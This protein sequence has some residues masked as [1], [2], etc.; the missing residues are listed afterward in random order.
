VITESTCPRCQAEFG[1]LRTD[2][3]T[4]EDGLKSDVLCD[5]CEPCYHECGCDTMGEHRAAEEASHAD[6]LADTG[7][8]PSW[9]SDEDTERAMRSIQR[10]RRTA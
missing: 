3:S 9:F 2:G 10:A 4:V 1:T 5:R 6:F 7:P 8:A